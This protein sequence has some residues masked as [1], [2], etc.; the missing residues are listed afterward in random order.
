MTLIQGCCNHDVQHVCEWCELCAHPYCGE[1]ECDDLE[2]PGED[3]IYS[4]L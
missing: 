3:D 2:L 1:C 4:G